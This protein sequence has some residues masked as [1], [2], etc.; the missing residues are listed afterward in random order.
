LGR[1]RLLLLCLTLIGGLLLQACQ[2]APWTGGKVPGQGR[3][4]GTLRIGLPSDLVTLDPALLTDTYS[5]QVSAQIHEP[6]FT[7]DFEQQIVPHLAA[8][9]DQPDPQTYLIALRQGIRFHNG[10]ELTADDGKFSFDRL[11]DPATGSPRAWRLTDA[12]E[13]PDSIE[14][15]DRYTVRIRLKAPFAPFLERLTQPA[16]FILSRKAVEAEGSQYARRPVGTG[17]FT[18]VEWRSGERVVLQRFDDYWAGPAKVAE[19]QVRPVPDPNTRLAEVESG[20]LDLALN[21]ASEE[22]ARLRQE[23]RVQVLTEEAIS[24]FYLGFNTGKPP[25][26]DLAVRQAISY[27]VDRPEILERL[28][29]GVGQVAVTGLNPS[30]WAFNPTTERYAYSPERA[31]QALG[32]AKAAL[33]QPLELAFNQVGEVTRVAERLQAQLKDN[34]GL[35]VVL[36]PMEWAAFLAYIKTGEQHQLYLLSWTGGSD[37]DSVL[38]PLFHSKN[39]GAAGNRTFYASPRVD[40]LL[41]QAQVTIDQEQRRQLYAEAQTLIMQDAPWLPIRHSVTAAAAGPNVQGYRLHPLNNQL[42]TAVTV[43]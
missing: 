7:V 16:C 36:K 43:R 42:L 22:L 11:M 15:L 2:A 34:L 5:G 37:P 35:Q 21:I 27:A 38:F 3:G 17:P 19:V 23:G 30:S 39:F 14:V 26:D 25:L 31:R 33:D 1:G 40:S 29:D 20:G 10:E 8:R 32:G 4:D 24:V 6:L 28:Y 9:L 41:S 18:F 12:L 13:S